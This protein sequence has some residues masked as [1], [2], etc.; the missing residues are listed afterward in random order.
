MDERDQLVVII[1][2]SVVGGLILLTTILVFLCCLLRQNKTTYE[3]RYRPSQQR[4]HLS[5]KYTKNPARSN[6]IDSSISVP[7]DPPHLINQNVKH[8]DHLL[9]S[10]STLTAKSWHYTETA[11]VSVHQSNPYEFQNVHFSSNFN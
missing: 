3:R 7:F 6:T 4:N 2:S 1:V 8:L 9:T 11:P 10:N 5:K